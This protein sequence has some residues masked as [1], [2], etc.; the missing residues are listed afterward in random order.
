MPRGD[1]SN[2]TTERTI[3]HRIVIT[4]RLYDGDGTPIPD[5]LIEIWQADAQ[6]YFNHPSDPNHA[7]ADKTFRG[8]GRSA[9]NKS[10]AFGFKTVK[11]GP[12]AWDENT[13]QAPHIS[14]RIF[15]RGMLNYTTTR[16]YFS[17]EPAN[18]TDPVLNSL[19]Q[20]ERKHTLIATLQYTQD[21]PSY[22]F[23]IHMQGEDETV[24]FDF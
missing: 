10:G 9:T 19:P 4:G 23:D 24:F 5:G 21:L 20:P 11:P 2:L 6:G 8:F 13:R 16:L 12:V 1:E 15:A 18:E 17:D 14:V 7:K 3:G 22:C